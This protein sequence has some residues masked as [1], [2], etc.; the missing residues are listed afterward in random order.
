LEVFFQKVQLAVTVKFK[1]NL[2]VNLK[3]KG[4]KNK[5]ERE[6]RERERGREGGREKGGKERERK[7]E[8]GRRRDCFSSLV[9]KFESEVFFLAA[10]FF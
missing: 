3:F 7:R 5:G 8:E 6:G 1:F 9:T 4:R 2:P 10:R